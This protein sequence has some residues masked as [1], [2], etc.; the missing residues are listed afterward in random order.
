MMRINIVLGF[1]VLMLIGGRVLAQ[2]SEPLFTE[3][4]A[5][6]HA[7]DGSGHTNVTTR[8]AV[9][10]LR[11]KRIVEMSD[12]DMYDSIA[13][14]TQHRDYPHA[15]LHIGMTE[16][17]VKGLVKYIRVLQHNSPPAPAKPPAKP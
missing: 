14:G 13:H 17:Q 11:S 1:V 6:C 2:D 15:F 5:K 3:K 8:L 16:E 4:C 10:D 12:S 7:K 9:P